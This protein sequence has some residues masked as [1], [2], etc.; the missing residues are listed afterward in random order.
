[1]QLVITPRLMMLED[2]ELY[3]DTLIHERVIYGWNDVRTNMSESF[4]SEDVCNP[5]HAFRDRDDASLDQAHSM[6]HIITLIVHLPPILVIKN[7]INI[8][9]T[10]NN[11]ISLTWNL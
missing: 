1:M 9:S 8:R 10:A 3:R 5:F 2:E 6:H 11:E 4:S 7:K